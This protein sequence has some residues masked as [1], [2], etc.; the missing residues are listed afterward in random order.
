MERRCPNAGSV[1]VK[2]VSFNAIQFTWNTQARSKTTSLVSAFLRLLGFI[3]F[4]GRSEYESGR[5]SEG[6][7]SDRT[8]SR[9]H[10]D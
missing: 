10:S 2:V 4:I 8:T 3:G 9:L 7:P 1:D 6:R 5:R